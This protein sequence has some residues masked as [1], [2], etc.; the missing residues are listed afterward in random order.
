MTKFFFKFKKTD[1]WPIFGPFSQNHAKILRKLTRLVDETCGIALMQEGMQANQFASA[2]DQR[3]NIR[4]FNDNR[5]GKSFFFLKT[6]RDLSLN[7]CVCHKE[8]KI[9]N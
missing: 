9:M 7:F 3:G 8:S 2:I 1:F 5:A 6:Q 4:N